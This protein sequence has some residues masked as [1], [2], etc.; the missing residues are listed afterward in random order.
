MVADCRFAVAE[1]DTG[2]VAFDHQLRSNRGRRRF[3]D[4][5]TGRCSCA[6]APNRWSMCC[7]ATRIPRNIRNPGSS[8]R[9]GHQIDFNL[10]EDANATSSSPPRSLRIIVE[11]DSSA[12]YSRTRHGKV[13][14][15]ESASPSPRELTPTIVDGEKT[16]HASAYFDLTQ[17]EAIYGLGQH[18]TGLLNQ[19][20]T[21]L[22]LMQDNTN[23]SVPFLL[24]SRGYGFYGTLP[25]WAATKT[26]SNPSSHCAPMLLMR[27][28]ITL[29]MAPSSTAS[30]PAIAS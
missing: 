3:A 14:A 30:L 21:D 19:R 22:L 13:L 6:C 1:S 20:G 18:Q 10:A 9:V 17:D 8:G 23:I 5:C 7:F 25:R 2:K 29:S 12:W 4:S 11:H 24:S 15:R 16:F 26:T 28:T 27:W